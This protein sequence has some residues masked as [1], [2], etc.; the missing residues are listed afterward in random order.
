[1]A[2][3]VYTSKFKRLIIYAISIIVI[4]KLFS[5][6]S[7][8]K[9]KQPEKLKEDI[10]LNLYGPKR[11]L[12]F[13]PK[14]KER[15]NIF[16][17]AEQI[18]PKTEIKQYSTSFGFSLTQVDKMEKGINQC[19]PGSKTCNEKVEEMCKKYDY[20]IFS[21]I[22]YEAKPFIKANCKAKIILHLTRPFDDFVPENEKQSFTNLLN[23]AI[24]S[25]KVIMVIPFKGY[26]YD[27]CERG[28]YCTKYVEVRSSTYSPT[29][30]NSYVKALIDTKPHINETM[31]VFDRYNQEK[32]LIEEFQKYG[33]KYEILD[34][35]Y[36]GPE[37]LSKYKAI[38]H[39]PYTPA[40]FSLMENIC[41]DV[42]IYVPTREFLQELNEKYPGKLEM[43][44]YLK[45]LDLR[46]D[47]LSMIF[48]CF[49]VYLAPHLIYFSSWKDLIA[50][51][52][53][54]SINDR[55]NLINRN[56][57]FAVYQEHL[58]SYYWKTLL[59]YGTEDVNHILNNDDIPY[60]KQLTSGEKIQIRNRQRRIE[61]AGRK[62]KKPIKKNYANQFS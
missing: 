58:N 19:E 3:L 61:I 47:Y 6:M 25:D 43:S 9:K 41:N 44:N 35:D 23:K 8:G 11:E 2:R 48:E 54:F 42:I 26:L 53:R 56:R 45:Y 17:F 20:L 51:L 62:K 22:L 7:K 36:G 49:D 33:I 32:Y 46:K 4:F 57:E 34:Y 12:K 30:K 31:A 16:H 55:T 27:A 15:K 37:V 29:I 14:K 13:I 59:G 1:M 10:N 21:D 18:N 5:L 40:P 50:K 24:A 38:V 52:K 60:C 28:L 39:I